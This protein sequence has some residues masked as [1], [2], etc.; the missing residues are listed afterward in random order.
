MIK[1]PNKQSFCN[2]YNIHISYC[3][4][5]EMCQVLD[6]EV[7]HWL[8]YLDISIHNTCL[9]DWMIINIIP[10]RVERLLKYT[11]VNK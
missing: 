10:Y 9:T 7:L 11:F 3:H 4:W 2:I 8:V 5:L 1:E 6:T